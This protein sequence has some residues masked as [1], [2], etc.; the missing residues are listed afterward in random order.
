MPTKDCKKGCSLKGSRSHAKGGIPGV[1][2]DSDKAIE[3]ESGE[4]VI[5]KNSVNSDKLFEF[6]GRKM[7]AKQILSEINQH[8]G[9][10]PIFEFGGDIPRAKCGCLLKSGGSI[11]NFITNFIKIVMSFSLT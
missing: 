2:T 8:K 6:E 11:P 4:V 1:V 7:K 10:V 5:S 3:V 9:G